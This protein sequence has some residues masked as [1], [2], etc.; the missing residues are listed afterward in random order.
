MPKFSV[1]IPVYNALPALS[2]CIESVIRQT[3]RGW[4]CIC[5]DDGS[6]DGSGAVLDGFA[7]RD[8]RFRI[9]HQP[10][11]GVSAA[12]NL[13]LQLARGD[14][15]CFVDADDFVHEDWLEKYGRQFACG[16]ADVVR[17]ESCEN[18]LL[19]G[20]PWK[21]AIKREIAIRAQFPEGVA[22]SEDS[23]YVARLAP[24]VT[25]VDVLPEM[26]YVHVVRSDSA[27]FRRLSS[28]ERLRFLEA[29][30]ELSESQK[31]LSRHVLSRFVADGILTWLGRPKDCRNKEKI[32]AE[33]RMLR[34]RGC[35]RADGVRLLLRI[36]YLCYALTGWLWPTRML[37]WGVQCAVA[38][39]NRIEGGKNDLLA[40]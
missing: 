4:E 34:A 32:R 13:G 31:D 24:F 29:V 7:K 14:F 20:F 18:W 22:M 36:P 19:D 1:I 28:E 35:T 6:T 25:K 30:R 16:N 10:N 17:L 11:A 8:S 33:W 27:M 5:V 3:D 40:C 26:T 23:L 39:K 15:V 9:F 12:R 38:L 2:A 37:L 21:Y